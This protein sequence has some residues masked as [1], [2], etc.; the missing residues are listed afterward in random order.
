MKGVGLYGSDFI[1]Q[2]QDESLVSENIIRILTTVPGE[3]VGNLGFGSRVREY[4]F[5]FRNVLLEDLEQVIISS[6]M[7]WEK[8]VNILDITIETDKINQEKINVVLNLQL[9]DNLDEFNLSIPIVF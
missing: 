2:R 7:A 4:L 5:N 9:K 1:Q 8:R 6:I 3:Q